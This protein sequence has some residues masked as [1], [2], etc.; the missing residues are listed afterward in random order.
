[1]TFAPFQRWRPNGTTM[2]ESHPCT[3]LRF[4]RSGVVTAGGHG[5][6]LVELIVVI[7]IIAVLVS[8]LLPAVRAAHESSQRTQCASQLR[9]VGVALSMYT[10]AN[11]GW[12]PAWSGWHTWPRGQPGDDEEGPAWTIELIPFI[13]PPDSA[14]YHCPSFPARCDN[15]FL[16]AV[17]ADANHKHA[18]KLTDVKMSSRFVVS[19][20][21]TQPQTY[22]PPYGYNP[23]P[24]PDCDLSDEG[25]DLLAFPDDGGFLM[26][27][28]GNNVMF[29]DFHVE[30]FRAFDPSSMTFDPT[31]MRSWQEVHDSAQNP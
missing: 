8:I 15:Y 14:V 31:Q 2:Y 10:T 20:D 16:A 3:P 7:G 19:G 21:V 13:G 6:S 1:M 22:A 29:D 25:I 30:A 24:V 26:H 11:K 28:G 4:E 17:W 5:F 9:Q 23:R 18:M 12:L 27:R